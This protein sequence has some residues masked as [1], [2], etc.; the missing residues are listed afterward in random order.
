M[1][2]MPTLAASVQL[3]TMKLVLALFFLAGALA[4]KD[5]NPA[6]GF[7]ERCTDI[8]MGELEVNDKV[9]PVHMQLTAV[10]D[11]I[12]TQL[13]VNIDECIGNDNGRL[14]WQDR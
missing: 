14:V 8:V 12:D 3:A 10:C 7:A 5:A 11:N 2:N 9:V 1:P 4:V 13:R 6:G